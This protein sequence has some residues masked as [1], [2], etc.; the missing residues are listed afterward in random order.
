[1]TI[2][3][4]L[5]KLYIIVWKKILIISIYFRIAR[6][7]DAWK[8]TKWL[9]Q[10]SRWCFTE[11]GKLSSNTLVKTSKTLNNIRI[12][13]NVWNS[14]CEC[15]FLFLVWRSA[16]RRSERSVCKILSRPK[17]CS[18]TVKGRGLCEWRFLYVLYR[19]SQVISDK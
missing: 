12:F 11:Q 17:S 7:S 2:S 9:R 18:W 3:F 16:W 1:M 14:V 4:H 8:A 5:P 19:Q 6:P 15:R 13:K 10:W